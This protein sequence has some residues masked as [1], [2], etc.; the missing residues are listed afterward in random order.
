[1]PPSAALVATSPAEYSNPAA[2]ASPAPAGS[3]RAAGP[4]AMAAASAET[5]TQAS[6]LVQRAVTACAAPPGS[7]EPV[8]RNPLARAAECP[9]RRVV[10][11]VRVHAPAAGVPAMD[12]QRVTRG[13]DLS[14]EEQPGQ[15]SG[16]LG[17][18]GDEWDLE[19]ACPGGEGG[20]RDDL[21]AGGMGVERDRDQALTSSPPT[22]KNSWPTAPRLS[23]CPWARTGG[24]RSIRAPWTTSPDV[25][26][27]DPRQGTPGSR[28]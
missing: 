1:M 12:D 10:F 26:P 16:R 11:P 4:A 5:T 6:G 19:A 14:A 20:E 18:L 23:C 28:D 21:V 2:T 22:W 9:G 17:V 7:V 15:P 3:T 25:Y 13:T 8:G 24:S 27:K